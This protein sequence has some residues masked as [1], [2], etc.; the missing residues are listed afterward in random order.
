MP[1]VCRSCRRSVSATTV[2]FR[3]L[4][5]STPVTVLLLLSL[6]NV[7]TSGK[8]G[9]QDEWSSLSRLPAE[10]SVTDR[11]GV[12][13]LSSSVPVPI[14]RLN[15]TESYSE[16]LIGIVNSQNHVIRASYGPFHVEQEILRQNTSSKYYSHT[17]IASYIVR[18]NVRTFRPAIK[19]VFHI[20]NGLEAHNGATNINLNKQVPCLKLYVLYNDH[21]LTTACRPHG[22]KL[23]CLAEVIVPQKWW[24]EMSHNRNDQVKVYYTIEDY[25]ENSPCEQNSDN[26]IRIGKLTGG[27]KEQALHRIGDVT[28]LSP[29]TNFDIIK[30]D[31]HIWLNVSQEDFFPG[32]QFGVNVVLPPNSTL[33]TFSL[34]AKAKRGIKFSSASEI[35]SSGWRVSS[36]VNP[37][38]SGTLINVDMEE[39]SSSRPNVPVTVCSFIFEV[40][41]ITSYSSSSA[42]IN[43]KIDYEMEGE[44][45][46]VKTNTIIN[47]LGGNTEAV[48][49]LRKDRELVNTALLN[50][51]QVSHALSIIAVDFDGEVEDITDR[52]HCSSG[53][54]A[55]LKVATD[56]SMVYMDGTETNGSVNVAVTVRHSHLS[57]FVNFSVYIPEF[58]LTVVVKDDKLSLIK[59]WKVPTNEL[60]D[61]STRN[62]DYSN[63]S[64]L[65]KEDTGDETERSR[66]HLRYQD[67]VVEVYTHFYAPGIVEGHNVPLFSESIMQRVTHLVKNQ[68]QMAD[69]NIASLH[70]NKVKGLSPG[71]TYVEV[72][73][74]HSN[75]LF[76]SKEIMVAG[77]K[78]SIREL[79]LNLVTGLSL[80]TKSSDQATNVYITKATAQRALFAQ[81]QKGFVD[82][83][84]LFDDGHTMS[85]HETDSADY[86]VE[87]DN[88]GMKNSKIV[89]IPR[90]HPPGLIAHEEGTTLVMVKLL[91]PESCQ[92]PNKSKLLKETLLFVNVEFTD[93]GRQKIMNKSRDNSIDPGIMHTDPATFPE[94]PPKD[95]SV[96]EH[97]KH[98]GFD[99]IPIDDLPGIKTVESTPEENDYEPPPSVAH[100]TVG[101]SDVEI[102]MYALLG[103]FCLAIIIFLINCV[104]FAARYKSKRLPPDM[105]NANAHD[106]MWL[107]KSPESLQMK[108]VIHETIPLELRSAQPDQ[109]EGSRG[110]GSGDDDSSHSNGEQGNNEPL[111]V[112]DN[113]N[114]ES[115]YHSN[116]GS[117]NEIQIIVNPGHSDSDEEENYTEN[118]RCLQDVDTEEENVRVGE[119]DDSDNDV[120][121]NMLFSSNMSTIEE[122]LPPSTQQMSKC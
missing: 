59:S 114:S 77:D 46:T 66:C 100:E 90:A 31:P 71:T 33:T 109:Q 20:T 117:Q 36:T 65:L 101:L 54:P 93:S 97:S 92:K 32:S 50:G 10:F 68:M 88:L 89:P 14:N 95:N 86:A 69:K 7:T 16:E 49:I 104:L 23:I 113:L 63:P 52:A 5:C 17:D 75:A 102:G 79:Q 106:W 27:Q 42:H 112:G 35:S 81:N 110:E 103:I 107:G 94:V 87:M 28:M 56:C 76:G 64:M 108:G 40:E 48:M 85:L 21:E 4:Y 74:P 12:F 72:I 19:V 121:I 58:P 22:H 2:V 37:K 9:N 51:N 38:Q 122:E 8:P 57:E 82:V 55:V 29:L 44:T 91:V 13:F 78:V 70:E 34:R 105:R 26:S 18:P 11:R 73:A 3:V 43:W 96:E 25:E 41:N 47:V 83:L 39:I 24:N 1:V 60:P 6:V 45:N 62:T 120:K 115:G 53:D 119:L 118:D 15:S 67:T 84:V 80:T 116:S 30:D 111:Q 99:T 98:S 61:R